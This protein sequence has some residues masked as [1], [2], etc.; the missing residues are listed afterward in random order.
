MPFSQV[1]SPSLYPEKEV[2]VQDRR[3]HHYIRHFE[4]AEKVEKAVFHDWGTY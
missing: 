4:K 2:E 1:L 3:S